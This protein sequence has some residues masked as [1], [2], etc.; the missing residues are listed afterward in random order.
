MQSRCLA[1]AF[2]PTTQSNRLKLYERRAVAVRPSPFPS[3]FQSKPFNSRGLKADGRRPIPVC[4]SWRN[5]GGPP[6]VPDRVVSAM[7]YLLPLFD[8]LRYGKFL[9]LQ[10]PTL[11]YVLAPFD[12]LIRVYFSVPF[13]GLIAFFAVYLGIINSP[14]FSR[15]VRYNAMQAVLLDVVLILPGLIE[16]VLKLR[17][18]G[19]PG[20]QLYITAYNTIFIFVFA[21]VAYGVASCMA[22]RTAK[23]PIVGDA[24]DAQ[25]R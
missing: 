8:G 22:G 7:P 19:G 12:P 4:A 3:P 1:L 6:S 15:Y 5:G 25:I 18:M 20:L 9:F 11:A 16:S 23:L 10:F 2:Q 13:A 17:P 14:N 24:A 21:C